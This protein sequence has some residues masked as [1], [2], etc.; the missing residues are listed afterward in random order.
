[1][2]EARA[3]AV[4]P[5]AEGTTPNGLTLSHVLPHLDEAEQNDEGQGQQLGSRKGV[6]HTG[7]SLHAVAVHSCEEHCG[8]GQREHSMS[9]R[10]AGDPVPVRVGAQRRSGAGWDPTEV[11]PCLPP[12]G[13]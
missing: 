13:L 4:F 10:R 3:Q 9:P 11:K 6:L 1:M 8:E 12:R 7:R 2:S 5:T